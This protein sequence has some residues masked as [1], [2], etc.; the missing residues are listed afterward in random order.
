[1]TKVAHISG[2]LLNYD[3]T[4]INIPFPEGKIIKD[5]ITIKPFIEVDKIINMPKIKTHAIT[6]Y[7]GAVKNLFGIVPGHYKSPYHLKYAYIREF[8]DMLIDLCLFAKPVLTVMDTVIGM[9]GLGPTDDTPRKVGLIL[10]SSNP[11]AL[12]VAVANIIGLKG[13]SVLTIRNLAKRGLCSGSLKDINILGEPLEKVRIL[14]YKLP[15]RRLAVNTFNFLLPK[16]LSKQIN[17]SMKS[18]P[19][20]D[21]SQCRRCGICMKSC[22]PKAI[23]MLKGYPHIN[24]SKCIPCFCCHELCIYKAVKIKTPLLVKMFLR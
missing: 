11:F 8:S 16:F 5:I 18:R 23:E 20:F 7:T 22:P 15:T 13:S 24:Y 9:E 3:T 19:A 1:M 4:E 21:H 17:N 2:A 6:I 10:A 12:D 14:D